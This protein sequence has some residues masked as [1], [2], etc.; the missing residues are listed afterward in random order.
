[1]IVDSS[2]VVAVL[3]R[4]PGHEPLL[5]QLA[6]AAG[7]GIGTPTLTETGIVLVAR[8]GATGR[9]LL[10]RFIEEAEIGEDLLCVGDDF[11]KTDLPLVR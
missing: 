4:E 11:A 2:A 8:L 7:A 6:S 5:G 9:T 1:M 10:G 3:L